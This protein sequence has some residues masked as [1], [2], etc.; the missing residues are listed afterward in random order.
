MTTGVG[1]VNPYGRTK[2][3][4]EEILKDIVVSD[5]EWQITSLR[6]FNPVGAH[7][8][9][10]IG[11][12]PSGVPNNLMPYVAQVAAGRRPHLNVFGDD[13]DTPD[14]AG[15]RD[16]VDVVDLAKGHVAALE[17]L[18]AAGKMEAYNIGTGHGASVLELMHAYERACGH[19]IPYKVT[20]RRAGDLPEYYADCT[21]ASHELGW[22]AEKTLDESCADS[23]RWQSMNPNGYR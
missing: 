13:Y 8:S 12:D 11:E 5:P 19:K 2:Y 20:G 6:Y 1:I 3:M 21:K 14:G 4:I 7:E 17:H 23:W 15:I 18:K 9:G 10:L 22:R 16:Y